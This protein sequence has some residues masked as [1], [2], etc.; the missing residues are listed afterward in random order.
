[1]ERK[2][3]SKG[4]TP[5]KTKSSNSLNGWIGTTLSIEIVE[6]R[7][8]SNMKQILVGGP[9]L[10]ILEVFVPS[11]NQ[12][13]WKQK[14]S[15]QFT[16]KPPIIFGD[17]FKVKNV[18]GEWGVDIK[19]GFILKVQLC[20]MQEKA[21]IH[22]DS[23]NISLEDLVV[24][25]EQQKVFILQEQTEVVLRLTLSNAQYPRGNNLTLKEI[26]QKEKEKEKVNGHTEK[27][28]V[29]LERTISSYSLPR[30]IIRFSI[31]YHTVLGEE[32]R[33]VGSNYKL[34]DWDGNK[35]PA[36]KWT[37]GDIWVLEISFRKAFVPLE[38]KYAL[39][40]VHNGD[41]RWETNGNRKVDQI[42]GDFIDRSDV[43][44]KI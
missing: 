44:D 30:V 15:S 22:I 5:H 35:A 14:S 6:V 11:N 38:Y 12:T 28:D 1:M 33:L 40:N 41:V 19:P 17:V 2:L 39:Y 7:A 9:Y 31:H 34:G 43:W 10:C 13:V 20:K 26:D 37:N 27:N 29:S 36:M 8:G 32:I 21:Q 16:N 24:N 4:G 23:T 42:E 18:S 25:R 3:I